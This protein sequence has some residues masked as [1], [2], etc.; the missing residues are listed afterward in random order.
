MHAHGTGEPY[1]CT[2][3]AGLSQLSASPSV[4]LLGT[5]NPGPTA[6]TVARAAVPC[7]YIYYKTNVLRTRYLIAA[8]LYIRRTVQYIQSRWK[9]FDELQYY[10]YVSVLIRLHKLGTNL[11]AHQS[12]LY[13]YETLGPD[14]WAMVIGCESSEAGVRRIGKSIEKL[15]CLD[16]R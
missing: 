2:V 11:V 10:C 3:P 5:P 9:E 14:R 15:V 8:A 7:V 12:N 6:S 4:G 1:A 13:L 16:Q